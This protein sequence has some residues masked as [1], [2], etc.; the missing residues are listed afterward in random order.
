MHKLCLFFYIEWTCISSKI[1]NS[2]QWNAVNLAGDKKRYS[3][4][5]VVPNTVSWMTVTYF[6]ISL[7]IEVGKTGLTHSWASRV[8]G[9][10]ARKWQRKSLFQIFWGQS[11]VISITSY[12]VH[13]FYPLGIFD[14][15]ISLYFQ[16]IFSLEWDQCSNFYFMFHFINHVHRIYWQLIT[17]EINTRSASCVFRVE[18]TSRGLMCKSFYW[19]KCLWRIKEEGGGI[20]RESRSTQV[21][22]L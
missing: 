20:N 2:S 11:S 7:S 18:D 6:L 8:E 16:L 1:N 12:F 13:P 3:N 14:L 19:L 17:F 10:W 22:H 15:C 4:S 5:S 21:W 9:Y